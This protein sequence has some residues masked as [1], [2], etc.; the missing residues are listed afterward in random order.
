MTVI[1]KGSKVARKYTSQTS[2]EVGERWE[3]HLKTSFFNLCAS[4]SGGLPLWL[5]EVN[6]HEKESLG[7]ETWLRALAQK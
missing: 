6:C 3:Q 5:C 1:K 4:S 2:E 7:A